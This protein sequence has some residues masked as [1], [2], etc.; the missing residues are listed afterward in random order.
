MGFFENFRWREAV[1]TGDETRYLQCAT[2]LREAGIL[3]RVKTQ[4]VGHANRRSGDLGALGE[5]QAHSYLYQI[6]VKKAELERS[7]H[8]CSRPEQKG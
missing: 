7:K 4:G 6:F 3:Y 8:I 5:S 2:A 1:V